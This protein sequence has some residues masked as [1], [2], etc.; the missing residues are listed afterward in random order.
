MSVQ[1]EI[2][3][4]NGVTVMACSGTITLGQAANTFRNTL[5]ELLQ[6][7]TRNLLLDLGGV[8]Y[9]DST[10]IGELVGAYTSAHSVNAQIKL[11]RVPDKVRSLLEITRLNTVF[12][13][14][15]DLAKAVGSFK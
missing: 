13:L 4:E 10:G 6:K 5:R 7:G 12:E 2:R 15:D 9:L 3:E 8:T 1:I 11:A 14:H